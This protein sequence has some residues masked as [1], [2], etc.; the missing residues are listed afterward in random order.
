M[1]EHFRRICTYSWQIKRKPKQQTLHV[2]T[3]KQTW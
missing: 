1:N 3:S 2:A